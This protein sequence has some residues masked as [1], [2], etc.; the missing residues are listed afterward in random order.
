MRYSAFPAPA[1]LACLAACSDNGE[2]PVQPPPPIALSQTIGTAGGTLA[3]TDGRVSLTIPP[4]ALDH[5]VVITID[6]LTGTMAPAVPGALYDLGPTGTTFAIPASL[7]IRYDPTRLASGASE[8]SLI[9]ARQRGPQE[10]QVE[11]ST[12]DPAAN[13]VSGEIW[14]FSSHAAVVH[15]PIDP[16]D[17]EAEYQPDR[18]I[19]LTA[20]GEVPGEIFI[21]VAKATGLAVPPDA[22]FTQFGGVRTL[23]TIVTYPLDPTAGVYWFRARYRYVDANN[24]SWL[25]LYTDPPARVIVFGLPDLPDRASTFTATAVDPRTVDLTF[26]FPNPGQNNIPDGYRIRRSKA[27]SPNEEVIDF[28][29]QPTLP[30]R[31]NGLVPDTEYSYSL[32]AFN[33]RGE[34]PGFGLNV[35]TPKLPPTACQSYTI[36]LAT[37]PTTA[38]RGATVATDVTVTRIGGFSGPIT[39]ALSGN[40]AAAIENIVLTDPAAGNTGRVQFKV[41]SDAPLGSTALTLDATSGDEFCPL[42]FE[43]D[44]AQP[45]TP[46]AGKLTS[47]PGVVSLTPNTSSAVWL[48]NPGSTVLNLSAAA[49]TGVGITVSFVPPIIGSGVAV[50][51]IRA[52]AQIVPGI[53]TVT[54]TGAGQGETRTVAI[55]VSLTAISSFSITMTSP[56]GWTRDNS[57]LHT[58]TLNRGENFPNPVTMSVPDVPAGVSEGFSPEVITADP[59]VP[60]S[61]GVHVF[62][63]AAP[64]LHIMTI[65]GTAGATVRTMRLLAVIDGQNNIPGQL[66]LVPESQVTVNRMISTGVS[67]P[68]V[69]GRP[70]A[71][72]GAPL[73][74]SVTGLPQGV[75]AAFVVNPA[76]ANSIM[77]LTA[78]PNAILGEQLLTLTAT[79]TNQSASA[80][81]R[82]VVTGFAP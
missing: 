9:V 73:T 22:A 16:P 13:R 39:L 36:A 43:F 18:T 1:L 4:G 52:G 55:E 5:D 75:T 79:A 45:T 24:V 2:D 67:V 44:V 47:R 29:I 12:V 60:L 25:G 21:E 20:T 54:I 56:L 27:G 14:S 41:K 23:N 11:K 69:I 68:I 30:Y 34:G 48:G 42:D 81:I 70:T 49:P 72:I 7:T 51:I 33:E 66:T 35:H 37:P 65:T 46:G 57:S 76:T 17:V 64:G 80:P 50:A 10:W 8:T 15:I 6:E 38:N 74:L 63:E 59:P 82:L 77:T 19:D 71:L 40:G 26:T 61:W 58:G 31:D 62:P 32:T 53:Y 78:T 28:P 3:S